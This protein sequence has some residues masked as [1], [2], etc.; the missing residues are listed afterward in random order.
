MFTLVSQNPPTILICICIAHSILIYMWNPPLDL[1]IGGAC[2]G[3]EREVC[4]HIWLIG[5]V[6]ECKWSVHESGTGGI[7]QDWL[8]TD[9]RKIALCT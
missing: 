6:S 9:V 4:N 8:L 1:W 5:G 7:Y 2:L 3:K